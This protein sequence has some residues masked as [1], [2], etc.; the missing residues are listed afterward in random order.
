MSNFVSFLF[1]IKDKRKKGRGTDKNLDG[2]ESEEAEIEEVKNL[3]F[4]QRKRIYLRTSKYD[5]MKHLLISQSET[6]TLWTNCTNTCFGVNRAMR[7]TPKKMTVNH[8]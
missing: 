1:L 8:T 7:A 6:T 2:N 4:W 5:N 3:F